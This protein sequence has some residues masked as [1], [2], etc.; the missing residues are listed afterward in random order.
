M[1]SFWGII[2]AFIEK[3]NYITYETHAWIN[4]H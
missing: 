4:I 2:R 3:S 1:F